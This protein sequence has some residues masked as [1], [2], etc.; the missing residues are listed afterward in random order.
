[1]STFQQRIRDAWRFVT[2]TAVR[3]TITAVVAIALT[4]TT[5]LVNWRTLFPEK[6]EPDRSITLDEPGDGSIIPRCLEIASGHGIIPK[7][8]HLWVAVMPGSSAEGDKRFT[9]VGKGEATQTSTR[10]KGSWKVAQVNAGGENRVNVHYRIFAILLSDDINS[11]VI[12][13]AVNVTD[14]DDKVSPV[15]GAARWRIEYGTLPGERSDPVEVIRKGSN[16]KTCKSES[17]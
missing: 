11:M 2:G 6:S 7:G 16:E 8:K 5:L 12:K 17:W 15:P 10:G 14:Y 4:V 9:L 3:K 13:S 1:M